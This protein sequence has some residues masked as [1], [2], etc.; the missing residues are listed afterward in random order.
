MN[1]TLLRCCALLL[2]LGAGVFG[3][4][5]AHAQ[6]ITCT[7]S[8][9]NLSFGNVD[10]QSTQTDTTA[11]LSYSCE[12][13]QLV[14]YSA[15]ICFSVGYTGAGPIDPREMQN[16]SSDKLYYQMYKNPARSEIWG[17]QFMGAAT[18]LLLNLNFPARPVGGA[19]IPVTGTATMWGR[20]SP[21]Q[22][23][24]IP[25]AYANVYGANHTRLT[26]NP[27]AINFPPGSCN[28]SPSQQIE[29]PFTVLATVIK[30]CTVS[31][32]PLNFGTGIG[33]LTTAIDA[34][35]TLG[36][37]CS[38]GTAYNVGLDAGQN[39]GG[40]INARKM[41]LGANT[42]GYQLYRDLAR[43][44]IWGDTIGSNTAT[45][46]GNGTTSQSLTVYGRVPVQTT[47]P[48]GTYSDTIIVTV[49][50]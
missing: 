23:T 48:A 7:A 41:K 37:Q 27:G 26:I 46:I 38:V 24:V 47:P 6:F 39:G 3:A 5:P 19:A 12:N 35:T 14:R 8:M 4:S 17:T 40:N 32:S 31:A 16:V 21:G 10:P 22:T 30:K 25:G 42:V 34:S 45:G 43:T 11:T 13:N 50:Y 1:H 36:V 2:L 33:L 20:V 44:Q 29:F 28:Q 15:T 9:S 18:P 49:T